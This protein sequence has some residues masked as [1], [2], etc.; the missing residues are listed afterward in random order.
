MDDEAAGV[1]DGMG[2]RGAGGSNRMIGALAGGEEISG[3]MVISDVV[4]EMYFEA[5]AHRYV[6][7]TEVYQETGH[8][9]RVDLPVVLGTE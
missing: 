4:W 7:C 1:P 6:A 2:S 3:R 8:E 5:I 9:E